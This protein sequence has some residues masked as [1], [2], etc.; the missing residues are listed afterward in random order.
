GL[1]NEFPMI[2]LPAIDLMAWPQKIFGWAPHVSQMLQNRM[3]EMLIHSYSRSVSNYL[4]QH[5]ADL[6]YT[7]SFK[8]LVKIFS[9]SP[10]LAP[11]LYFE[12]HQIPWEA[13][14]HPEKL[15]ILNRIG[16]LITIT[17][18][19]KDEYS[20]YGIEPQKIIVAPDGVNIK[21]F[22]K[23]PDQ[24]IARQ[25]LQVPDDHF[26]IGYVGHLYPWKGID[27]LVQSM[28]YLSPKYHLILVGGLPAD[29]RRVQKQVAKMKIPRTTLSGYLP[30]TEILPYLAAVDVLVLPTSGKEKMGHYYTSPLKLFEYMAV[31]R[32]IVA[33]DL[34][35]TRE[36]LQ[37]QQNAYLVRADDP[38]SLAQGIRWVSEHPELAQSLAEQARLEVQA[39]SWENRAQKI[40]DFMEREKDC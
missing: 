32:P 33:S 30:P 23:I 28:L 29:I 25:A 8:L 5:S 17:Q 6:Y 13:V 31:G 34:P 12:G 24:K 37:H 36:I 1:S 11:R 2:E 27:P 18:S 3:F 10:R 26:L 7:R 21:R 40:I 9:S 35:S 19:L 4:T 39:Y 20:R 15:K 22:G 38:S 16:G 14:H